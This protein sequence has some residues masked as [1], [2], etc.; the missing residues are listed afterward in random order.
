MAHALDPFALFGL[1]ENHAN[2]AEA[3][4]A[5]YALAMDT[6]PDRQAGNAA[7]FR[8]V[9]S[10]WKWVEEQ[11]RDVP[12]AGEV[13]A[14]FEAHR[15]EWHK[16]MNASTVWVPPTMREVVDECAPPLWVS[17]GFSAYDFTPADAD[18]FRAQ[19]DAQPREGVWPAFPVRGYEVQTRE[20][21]EVRAFSPRA[22]VVYEA[23]DPSPDASTCRAS[24]PSGVPEPEDLS[25]LDGAPMGCDYRRAMS[26]EEG[27]LPD[28]RTARTT[29]AAL[30]AERAG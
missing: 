22:V 17:N 9:H 27:L 29:L 28:A 15:E 3:R 16:L 18:A 8:V 5:Y 13:V 7:Q 21:G 4:Q 11:L 6:H 20:D 10:A 12:D 23:P 14:R 26:E 30:E 19:W 24:H 2:I 1:N 25:V